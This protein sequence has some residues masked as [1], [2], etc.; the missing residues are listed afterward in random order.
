M[1]LTAKQQRFVEEYLKDLNA[2]AAGHRAG[3]KGNKGRQLVAQSSAVKEAIAARSKAVSA[4]AQLDAKWVLDRLMAIADLDVSQAFDK[5]GALKPLNEMPEATRQA[6]AGLETDEL[7]QG[8]GE[9]RHYVG[10]ARKVRWWDKVKALELLGKH[11]GL[12]D[13]DKPQGDGPSMILK[14]YGF[15]PFARPAAG[16]PAKG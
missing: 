15:N 12:F 6:I 1:K 14:C 8:R 10:Q 5:D 16:P 2:T 3:Y 4:Q 7:Y 9:D 11:L 13:D